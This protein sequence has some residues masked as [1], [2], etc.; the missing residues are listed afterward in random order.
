MRTTIHSTQE[1]LAFQLH[2]LFNIES[3]V[4][5]ELPRC[6]DHVTSKRVRD[7]IRKYVHES[8]NKLT[9]LERVFDYL[10][11]EP[12]A[13]KNEVVSK[14]LRETYDMLTY[15]SSPHLKDMLIVGCIQNINAYKISICRSAYLFAVEIELDSVTDLLQ[16]FLE[17]E[18]ETESLIASLAIEEFNEVQPIY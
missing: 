1:A 17:S 8:R 6:I 18:L 5:A 2:G 10:M 12:S 4:L 16:Q 3:R 13:R 7:E 14:M 15:K 9:K 11:Y